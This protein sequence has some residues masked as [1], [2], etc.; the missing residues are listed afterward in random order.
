M[1]PKRPKYGNVRVKADGHEFASKKEAARYFELKMLARIGEI[2]GL[3]LQPRFPLKV[4][5]KL[6]CTYVGDFSYQDQTGKVVVEDA[7]GVRTR[8]YITK[9]KLFEALHG[10]PIREV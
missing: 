2:T 7:K 1:T 8:E 9:S 10:F 6:V 5:G 4:N 3:E